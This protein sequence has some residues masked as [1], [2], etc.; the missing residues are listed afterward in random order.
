MDEWQLAD[1]RNNREKIRRAREAAEELFK[2]AQHNPDAKPPQSTTNEGASAEQQPRRRPRIFAVPPQLTPNSQVEPP[3]AA[4]PVRR[5]VPEKQAAAA[6]PRSQIGRVRALATYG[7]TP[8]QVADLYGVTAA[9]IDRI[10]KTP[11]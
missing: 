9:E 7:M 5:K 1:E 8:Q 10:L 4:E 11:V 3:A 6:V 2:P